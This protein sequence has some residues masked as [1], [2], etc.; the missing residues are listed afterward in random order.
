MEVGLQTVMECQI[1]VRYLFTIN[2]ESLEVLKH[3]DSPITWRFN[4][5]ISNMRFMF[6]MHSKLS[7][8]TIPSS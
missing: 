2:Q 7:V 6:D 1:P 5:Q 8:H 3:S 4:T